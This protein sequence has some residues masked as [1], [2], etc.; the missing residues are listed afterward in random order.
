MEKFAQRKP[1]CEAYDEK[2]NFYNGVAAEIRSQPHT[3]VVEFARVNTEP[4]ATSLIE[5]ARLWVSS[6]GRRL[7]DLAREKLTELK[8]ELEVYFKSTCMNNHIYSTLYKRLERKSDRRSKE[9][10]QRKNHK[11]HTHTHTKKT[12]QQQQQQNM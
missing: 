5:N 8:T 2:M 6:L 1:S 9:T 11:T 10:E 4:L 12:P 7:N 3:E